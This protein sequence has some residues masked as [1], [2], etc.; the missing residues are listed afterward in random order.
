MFQWW[1][2]IYFGTILVNILH[3]IAPDCTKLFDRYVRSCNSLWSIYVRVLTLPRFS[4]LHYAV[5]DFEGDRE[6]HLISLAIF[7]LNLLW[8]YINRK[9]K[10]FGCCWIF[11]VGCD[12][13]KVVIHTVMYTLWLHM[14][15][16]RTFRYIWVPIHPVIHNKE[17]Q[18]SN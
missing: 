12:H 4:Y 9:V 3:G 7:S 5:V 6:R 15:T 11:I 1:P 13:G 16:N 8:N 17:N 18:L 2:K 10:F 14:T